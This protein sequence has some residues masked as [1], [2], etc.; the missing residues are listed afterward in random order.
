MIS[1]LLTSLISPKKTIRGA[2][3]LTP[4][5]YFYRDSYD[6]AYKNKDYKWNKI[7]HMEN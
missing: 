3:G 5:Q 1:A 6:C 2:W 4:L 7:A